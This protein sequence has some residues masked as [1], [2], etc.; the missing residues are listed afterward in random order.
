MCVREKQRERGEEKGERMRS[1]TFVQDQ[2]LS[3]DFGAR[4]WYLCMLVGGSFDTDV[5]IEKQKHTPPMY[6]HAYTEN[7]KK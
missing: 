4:S 7:I 6:T 3:G 1:S 2:K 5:N